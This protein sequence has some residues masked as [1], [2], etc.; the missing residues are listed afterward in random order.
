[1]HGCYSG[2]WPRVL[3]LSRVKDVGGG[4]SI[5]RGFVYIQRTGIR[6][7][8]A[9]IEQGPDLGTHVMPCDFVLM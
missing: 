7:G 5:R 8:T 3:R 6:I 2:K 4:Y 1:M 9:A